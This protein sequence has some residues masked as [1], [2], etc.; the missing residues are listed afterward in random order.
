MLN[1]FYTL[2]KSKDQR[3]IKN[4]VFSTKEKSAIFPFAEKTSLRNLEL[5]KTKFFKADNK[6]ISLDKTNFNTK[7]NTKI[8]NF[9]T[10]NNKNTY[11][12][13]FLRYL[14]LKKFS[15]KFSQKLETRNFLFFNFVNFTLL[16][17]KNKFFLVSNFLNFKIHDYKQYLENDIRDNKIKFCNLLAASKAK[18]LYEKKKHLSISLP[19]KSFSPYFSEAVVGSNANEAIKTI[20]KSNKNITNNTIVSLNSSLNNLNYFF[21]SLINKQSLKKIHSYFNKSLKNFYTLQKPFFSCLTVL[22]VNQQTSFGQRS[23]EK[24]VF[25]LTKLTD[26]KQSFLVEEKSLVSKADFADK[27]KAH[28]KKIKLTKQQKIQNVNSYTLIR[29]SINNDLIKL[30]TDDFQIL[31]P[32][33]KKINALTNLETAF[34][35]NLAA[36]NITNQ[37]DK[38]VY[39]SNSILANNLKLSTTPWSAS[40]NEIIKTSKKKFFFLQNPFFKKH[41]ESQITNTFFS[42]TAIL[43]FKFSNEK[44]S[45]IFLAEEIIYYLEKKVPFFKIKNKLLKEISKFKNPFLK[46]LKVTCSGRVGGRSKKAQRAKVQVIKYGQTSLHVFSSKIDFASKHAYTVF[47]LLG[48]KVWICYN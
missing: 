48:V 20:V 4:E 41:L 8:W 37:N 36:I 43:F 25:K 7:L 44:Q 14:L 35:N 16:N 22:P 9:N 10:E 15:L 13:L 28:L 47:G 3:S 31:K 34:K 26:L 42:D 38:N 11:I 33:K 45:A 24:E 1:N 39:K 32:L 46:G 29:E 2:E 17:N 19:K 12:Q 18:E 23:R 27:A 40:L 5:K 6:I 30:V 21:L